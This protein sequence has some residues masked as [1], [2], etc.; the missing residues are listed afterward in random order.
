V[1]AFT[2][3]VSLPMIVLIT[4]LMLALPNLARPTLPLGVSVPQSRVDEPVIAAALRRFR[5]IVVGAGAI[6]VVA[7]LVLVWFAP[8]AS[9]LVSVLG[10]ILGTTIAYVASRGAILRAKRDGGWYD[11]VPVRIVAA[12]GPRAVVHMPYGWLIASLAV[13][14]VVT[15]VGVAVYPGLP[16]P[17]PV[18]W[19]ISG[20]PDRFVPKSVWAVFSPLVVMGA[21][22]LGLFAL[23]YLTRLGTVRSL[24]SLT[25]EQN[26]RRAEG[27][28]YAIVRL[29]ARMQFVIVLFTGWLC[30]AGWLFPGSSAPI[31]VGTLGLLPVVALLVVASLVS[32]RRANRIAVPV[33]VAAGGSSGGAADSPDDDSHW[34]GGILYINR[35]DP[36]LFV[37]R[38][39]GVGWTPNLGHPG[40]VAIAVGLLVLIAAAILVPIVLRAAG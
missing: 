22:A 26:A 4:V 6:A 20:R 24:P 29:I 35:D 16:D 38:R 34:R 10:L 17:T 32:F 40:G 11:D 7:D 12:T 19:G 8:A 28:Q 2:L 31:L 25:A 27:Q 5:L 3:F 1:N 30:L 13:I 9:I 14:A 33:G 36:A 39:L 18:H 15:A 23:G 21:V 37:P